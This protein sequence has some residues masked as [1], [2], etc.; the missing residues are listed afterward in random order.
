VKTENI[1]EFRK[2]SATTLPNDIGEIIA[3]F[4]KHFAKAV[5]KLANI[6]PTKTTKTART[7]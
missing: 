2:H 4:C 1:A 6:C 5:P 7:L 3:K